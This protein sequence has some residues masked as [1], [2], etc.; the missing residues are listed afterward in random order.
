MVGDAAIEREAL[1]QQMLL[2]ALW[3]DA[4]PGVVAGWMRDDPARFQRGLLAYQAN[5]AALAERALAAAFPVLQQLIGEASFA[6]MA[7]V[8]W[9]Q[10]PPQRGDMACWGDVLPAF[11][12][13]SESLADEPYLADVARLEWALHVV[14]SAADAPQRTLNLEALALHE[15]AVLRLRLQPGMALIQSRHPIVGIWRAHQADAVVHQADA[16]AQ[17]A[18]FALVREAFAAGRGETALVSRSGYRPQLDAIDTL[19][20]TF[21]SALLARQTLAAALDAAGGDFHFESWLIQ[22]LQKGWISA[23]ETSNRSTS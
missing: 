8:F 14:A 1:R 9:R 19:D 13:D 20:A 10:H 11:V 18:A 16:A 15:P 22:A 2:R 21:M 7:R 12:A 6:T 5:A 4:R 23:V 3:R 17:E